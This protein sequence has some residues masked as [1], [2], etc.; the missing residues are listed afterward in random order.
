MRLAYFASVKS[1]LHFRS[2][3]PYSPKLIGEKGL[4]NAQGVDRGWE[5]RNAM[6]V[7]EK[8]IGGGAR[9]APIQKIG[10]GHKYTE[11]YVYIQGF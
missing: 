2:Y 11:K 3:V 1:H 5:L 6:R 4:R 8:N 7:T 9:N 10:K